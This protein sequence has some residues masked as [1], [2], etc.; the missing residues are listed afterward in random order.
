MKEIKLSVPYAVIISIKY[1]FIHA[2][3][4][5]RQEMNQQD[6]RSYGCYRKGIGSFVFPNFL[7]LMFQIS[8]PLF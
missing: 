5:Y 4:M 8:K 6:K 7:V 3:Y 2:E 1:I